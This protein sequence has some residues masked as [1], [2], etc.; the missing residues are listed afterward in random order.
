MDKLIKLLDA[1]RIYF[2]KEEL[3]EIKEQDG[4]IDL[5]KKT[6][7]DSY[8]RPTEEVFGDDYP[9]LVELCNNLGFEFS[10]EVWYD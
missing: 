5:V 2:T 1:Y 6:Y 7:G 3:E 10:E 9:K 8:G 4:Y